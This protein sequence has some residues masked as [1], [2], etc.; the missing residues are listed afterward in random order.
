VP[1]CQTR[2]EGHA[3]AAAALRVLR[4]LR[5]LRRDAVPET[6][7][8]AVRRPLIIANATGC[9]SIYGGN[10]P[11]TPY[12]HQRAGRGPA[13]ANSLFEDNAEFGLG[14]RLSVD[15][16]D[17]KR[18]QKLVQA[19]GAVARPT[20]WSTTAREPNAAMPWIAA[21]RARVEELRQKLRLAAR[22]CRKAGCRLADYLVPKSVWLVGGDGW[23]FDIGFG[24]LDHVLSMPR[25]RR[26]RAGARHRGLQQH[27]RPGLEGD[28]ARGGGEVRQ[29]A[30]RSTRRTSA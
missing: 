26:Q 4:R 18:A 22:P 30:R 9:S 12:A 21:Q 16:A 15:A 17:A 5:R 8:A 1:P 11:T 7:H 10:L 23:A 27:R 2:R 14:M 29:P 3:V 20:R 6:A 19:L 28:S 13:W 24:G 25:A